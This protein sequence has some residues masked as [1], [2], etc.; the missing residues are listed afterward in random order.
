MNAVENLQEGGIN[1]YILDL[2]DNGGGLLT[3][4]VETARLFLKDGIILQQQY[5]G[6]E[7]E[8][9]TTRSPGPLS[10]IPLVVLINKNTASAAEI[11]AGALQVHSRAQL[12]G[13]SSFGKDTIQLIFDLEDDSSLHIT[14]AKWWIPGIDHPIGDSGLEPDIQATQDESDFDYYLEAAIQALKVK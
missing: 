2:R 9:F 10:D 5:R 3:A 14:A 6:E 13:E 1:K 4:S 8:T 11:I 7:V 12:I